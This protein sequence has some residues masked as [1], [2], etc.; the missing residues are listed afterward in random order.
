[1]SFIVAIPARYQSQRLPE[2]MLALIQGKAMLAH[3]IEQ[4]KKS[5]AEKVMVATDDVRIQE[6]V[7]AT[8]TAVYLTSTEHTSGTSRLAECVTLAQINDDTVVVNVQ[9]DEPLIAPENINQVA[10][11]L[12]SNE[13]VCMAS[14]YES[15]RVD[16]AFFDPNVVKVV[17]DDNH[18]ALY[19]SRAPIPWDRQHFP[20][21][22]RQS[23]LS[24]KKHIGIYAYRAGFLKRFVRESVSVLSQTESLEQLT[25]LAMGET[26]QMAE[27]IVTGAIGVDTSEDLD[28]VS[29]RL[30]QLSEPT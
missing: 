30:S 2:K 26:I 17:V 15:H 20:D 4:A 27:A 29:A 8:D 21:A 12:L 9:G 28:K 19:F 24:Y 22:W 25:V 5:D 23:N 3:V 16:S 10:N 18:C 6:M 7:E 14:L 13:H 11:L 1:M